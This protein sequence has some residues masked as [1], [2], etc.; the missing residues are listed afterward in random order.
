MLAWLVIAIC[1][2]FGFLG[3]KKGLYVMWAAL[4]NLLFAVFVSILSTL[5][6]LSYSPEYERHGY[7]ASLGVFLLF[8]III[9][10]IIYKK[11]LTTDSLQCPLECSHRHTQTYCQQ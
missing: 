8:S 7:Y 1:L 9:K 2:G 6:L 10:N 4:F 11:H 3:L 5:R